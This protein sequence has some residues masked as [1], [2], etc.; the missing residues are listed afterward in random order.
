MK[1]RKLEVDKGEIKRGYIRHPADIPIELI[2]ETN[3]LALAQSVDDRMKIEK[4]ENVSFGGLMFQS[5]VP[6]TQS[7]NMLVKINSI[8]PPFEAHAVVSWCR[9]SGRFYM[10]GL[11]FADKDAEFKIR[12]VEQICHIMH[13]RNQVLSEE[14]RELGSEEAAKEWIEHYAASFPK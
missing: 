10:V 14:G 3:P 4:M 11:E 12:M 13:Y 7:R 2:P 1:A 8:K 5:S 6:Y 9:K